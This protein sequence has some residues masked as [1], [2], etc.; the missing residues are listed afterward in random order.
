MQIHTPTVVQG[1]SLEPPPRVFDMLHYFEM[2][3]P[4]MESR[5]SQQDEA[6]SMGDEAAGGM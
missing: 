4:S 1:G 3:L 6:Y 5:Y 2:I